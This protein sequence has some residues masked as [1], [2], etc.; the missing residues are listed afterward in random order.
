MRSKVNSTRAENIA[1][2]I[3]QNFDDVKSVSY[4]DL[5]DIC[6]IQTWGELSC[7]ELDM[8]QDMVSSRIA[9]GV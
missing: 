9:M 2:Y 1:A 4:D 3:L 6:D 7:F 5:R 8:L